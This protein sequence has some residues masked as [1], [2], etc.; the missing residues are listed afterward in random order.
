MAGALTR[1]PNRRIAQILITDPEPQ[2]FHGEVVSRG[3]ERVGYMRA[4]SYGLT[5]GAA[6][7]L[8]MIEAG[9]SVTT[10]YIEDGSWEVE[11]ADRIYPATASLR[12][13]YDP[14]SARVR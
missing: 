2:M 12:P 14:T 4:A 9:E 8:A 13:L 6:V 10:A 1:P 5:L 11:V 7:G 3:A